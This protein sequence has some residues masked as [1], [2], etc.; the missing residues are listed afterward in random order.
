MEI[1]HVF[2]EHSVEQKYK[3]ALQRQEQNLLK[4]QELA[5]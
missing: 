5:I 2:D 4:Y 1:F 3:E